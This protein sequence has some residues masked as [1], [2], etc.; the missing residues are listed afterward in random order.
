EII[1]FS[2]EECLPEKRALLIKHLV[3][4]IRKVPL[5]NAVKGFKSVL[6]A[7][8]D[9]DVEEKELLQAVTEKHQQVVA[10]QADLDVQKLAVNQAFND[11]VHE[12][13]TQAALL[14]FLVKDNLL[15]KA[16]TKKL[17]ITEKEQRLKWFQKRLYQKILFFMEKGVI[18][19]SNKE[20]FFRFAME[21]VEEL[22]LALKD[23]P[24]PSRRFREFLRLERK[25][26]REKANNLKKQQEWLIQH[27]PEILEANTSSAELP[28]ALLERLSSP[29]DVYVE[30]SRL[31]A[32]IPSFNHENNVEDS[33]LPEEELPTREFSIK[34]EGEQWESH[35]K[36][37][38][39]LEKVL[40]DLDPYIVALDK[41]YSDSETKDSIDQGLADLFISLVDLHQKLDPCLE[42][43]EEVKTNDLHKIYSLRLSYASSFSKKPHPFYANALGYLQRKNILL[44]KNECWE[45]LR[46]LDDENEKK[47]V[48]S[49]LHEILLQA[50][51]LY[52][53]MQFIEPIDFLTIAKEVLI[54]D[55]QR[56]LND[57]VSSSEIYPSILQK[58]IKNDTL[59]CKD[60]QAMMKCFESALEHGEE[61]TVK[62]CLFVL[63]NISLSYAECTRVLTLLSKH[64]SYQEAFELFG[65]KIGQQKRFFEI[66]W[67]KALEAAKTYDHLRRQVDKEDQGSIV[68]LL[69]TIAKEATLF[70]SDEQIDILETIVKT[71]SQNGCF[72]TL[73]RLKALKKDLITK[74]GVFPI[75]DNPKITQYNQLL[76]DEKEEL[77][78]LSDAFLQVLEQP[79][80]QEFLIPSLIAIQHLPFETK[81][82]LVLYEIIQSFPKSSEGFRAVQ[83]KPFFFTDYL[84]SPE[85]IR[86]KKLLTAPDGNCLVH[87]VFGCPKSG[88]VLSNSSK[89]R[90][91]IESRIL[92]ALSNQEL[93]SHV[94]VKSFSPNNQV[95]EETINIRF[96]AQ[97][98]AKDG[99]WLGLDHA[100]LIAYLYS[101]N[102]LVYNERTKEYIGLFYN[103]DPNQIDRL[104]S[105]NGINHWSKH[106]MITISEPISESKT[107]ADSEA[108]NTPSSP[109]S[110]KESEIKEDCLQTIRVLLINA[111][112][113]NC[114]TIQQAKRSTST[115]LL[116]KKTDILQRA[117]S[118]VENTQLLHTER[119]LAQFDLWM[120]LL[121]YHFDIDTFDD[122]TGVKRQKLY[123]DALER[124]THELG[125]YDSQ[126]GIDH[127][128]CWL[129]NTLSKIKGTDFSLDHLKVLLR[130][131]KS[132]GSSKQNASKNIKQGYWRGLL[133]YSSRKEEENSIV[134][135]VEEANVSEEIAKLVKFKFDEGMI[136]EECSTMKSELQEIHKEHEGAIEKWIKGIQEWLKVE[137]PGEELQK[138]YPHKEQLTHAIN[139]FQI[140][141]AISTEKKEETAKDDP[142]LDAATCKAYIQEIE[143]LAQKEMLFE[144]DMAILHRL[145]SLPIATKEML[146]KIT[147]LEI[148]FINLQDKKDQMRKEKIDLLIE[149]LLVV[150]G[151]EKIVLSDPKGPFEVRIAKSIER[152]R[153]TLCSGITLMGEEYFFFYMDH[154][155]KYL[156]QHPRPFSCEE[157]NQ[158]FW[159]LPRLD[160]PAIF[161]QIMKQK[162]SE[163]WAITLLERHCLEAFSTPLSNM[164]LELPS[165]NMQGLENHE[166]EER[167]Q[168]LLEEKSQLCTTCL[169]L[170]KKI[171]KTIRTT[172]YLKR[173]DKENLLRL[174][175]DRLVLF[176]QEKLNF[177]LQ[178]FISLLENYLIIPQSFEKVSQELSKEHSPLANLL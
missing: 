177:S 15:F 94:K 39:D 119:H 160:D 166:K 133:P 56:F 63:L 14:K 75:Q 25:Q 126:E 104:I 41:I 140:P 9:W 5:R 77:E 167:I 16:Q 50:D 53:T 55:P 108:I 87:A 71:I 105:Y 135:V 18:D 115:D 93:P 103:S 61:K 32:K 95:V 128:H 153:S 150:N 65:Y 27:L 28:K 37:L 147:Q 117:R 176:N 101:L 2:G 10:F 6:K 11:M 73:D 146:E 130:E 91:E 45:N 112:Q 122:E 137:R 163:N 66:K 106:Q 31:W 170:F 23:D 49:F 136:H 164:A 12:W 74:I 110:E 48:D 96:L 114:Q 84:I 175:A 111:L 21:K 29:E 129:R 118:I 132:Q 1:L 149:Q 80:Q 19:R 109:L 159:V 134:K 97:S 72:S 46:L 139:Y 165:L 161:F 17:E 107:T 42:Q 102:I 141:Q 124:L 81:Q 13:T 86:H 52:R 51:Q 169:T 70:S 58:A 44:T 90:K 98:I 121:D 162:L 7:M 8:K 123:E 36:Q 62:T 47:R 78:K 151:K 4:I 88:V 26:I 24:S 171:L 83:K 148:R 138:I 33:L 145:K 174:L 155:I 60:P 68:A 20:I 99:E 69:K 172:Q 116:K 131:T 57:A 22:E 127:F 143:T 40:G 92:Q 100:E 76:K 156:K 113:I 34:R 43:L 82:L 173:G 64:K 3:D 54:E 120:T 178:D 79:Y 38:L 67:K 158:L 144:E 125:S 35:L 168:K 142:T 152:L 30:C 59:S 85:G 89:K 154:F 157:A